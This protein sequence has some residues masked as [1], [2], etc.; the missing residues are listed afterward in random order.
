MSDLYYEHLVKKERT[1]K[2][3]VVKFGLIG[4]TAL[5]VFAGLMI[6]FI[7]LIPAVALGVADYFIL[8]KTDLEYEYLFVN[9]E[10]DVDM[11]MS[12]T[13]RK[14]AKSFNIKEADLVAPVKSHRMDYHNNNQKMK[15]L[16][17]SSGN[18]EHLRFAVITRDGTEAVKIIIE[19]D[20]AMA[21]K[22]KDC[23]PSKVYLD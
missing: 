6:S 19:P 5:F 22:M 23:A 17:Y 4:L 3:T 20:E 13:K 2:D 21:R 16:D 18:P 1:T 12:K 14:R 9:G 8:P 11:V 7:F 10:I 15:V